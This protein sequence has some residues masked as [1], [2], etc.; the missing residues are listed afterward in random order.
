MN[1]LCAV[2][3]HRLLP[4]EYQRT[5][6]VCG[7]AAR[8][9]SAHADESAPD[10]AG[11]FLC[12]LPL[13][14]CTRMTGFNAASLKLLC[15]RQEYRLSHRKRYARAA[16]NNREDFRA[17]HRPQ[18]PFR[19]KFA[20]NPSVHPKRHCFRLLHRAVR[21]H[22]MILCIL[23]RTSGG[24]ISDCCNRTAEKRG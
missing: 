20:V 10:I 22:R 17:I 21:R 5:C 12:Q 1:G 8:A 2:R 14:K 19:I 15:R 6:L 3:Q 9:L 11:S 24:D 13:R 16:V 4:G 7:H 23:I 18:H